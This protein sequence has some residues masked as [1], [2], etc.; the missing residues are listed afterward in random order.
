MSPSLKDLKRR[1]DKP[2]RRVTYVYSDEEFDE[3]ESD[4]EEEQD[5]DSDYE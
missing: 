4:F 5:E 2:P 1:E 3:E